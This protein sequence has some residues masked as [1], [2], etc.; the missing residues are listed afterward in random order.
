[1]SYARIRLASAY[2]QPAAVGSTET[3]ALLQVKKGERV[4]WVHLERLVLAAG[5]TTST[6]EI[7]DGTDTD[8]FVAAIDTEAGA[9]GDMV[10]GAGALLANSGG[11]LYTVDD[12]IDAVYTIGATPGATNP[13]VRVVAAIA[14]N[15]RS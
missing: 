15:S 1:M 14:V 5:S 7:G 3:K 10:A 6:I 2:Y 11:K 12:T 13:S 4:L 9:A 8:G